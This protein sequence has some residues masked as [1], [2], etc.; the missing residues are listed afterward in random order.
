MDELLCRLDLTRCNLLYT[1]GGHAYAIFP[2]T[3]F[4]LRPSCRGLPRELKQWLIESFGVD[5]FCACVF[6][7]CLFLV[8]STL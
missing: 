6:Q 4:S 2:N 5:L 3:G 8:E 1:G 7:P